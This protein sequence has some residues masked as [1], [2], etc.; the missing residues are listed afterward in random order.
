MEAVKYISIQLKFN[1]RLMRK[2]L[3]YQATKVP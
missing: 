3:F 1:F 2:E